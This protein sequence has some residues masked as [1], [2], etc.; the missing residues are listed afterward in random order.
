MP[1][2]AL[3]QKTFDTKTPV[4]C[5]PPPFPPIILTPPIN[6]ITFWAYST[7]AS[8]ASGPYYNQ[9]DQCTLHYNPSFNFWEG[10]SYASDKPAWFQ[11]KLTPTPTLPNYNLIMIWHMPAPYGGITSWSNKYFPSNRPFVG[12][13]LSKTWPINGNTT[14]I[15]CREL[16]L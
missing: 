9:A 12:N 4:I 2:N 3:S 8:A 6:K 11:A 14:T 10:N 13:E 16:P 1:S 15:R 7:F 5:K